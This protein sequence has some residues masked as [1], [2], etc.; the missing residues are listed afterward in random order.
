MKVNTNRW[1]RI[2]YTIWAPIYDAVGVLLD[3]MRRRSLAL[4]DI[5][6]D[7]KVL[8]VGCGTGLDLRYIS[9]PCSITATDITPAMV[10]RTLKRGKK[11]RL[12]V[13]ALVMD[14]QHLSFRDNT[15]D[16]IILHLIVAVVPVPTDALREAERVLKPGGTIVVLDK[17]VRKGKKPSMLRKVANTATSVLFSDI[18]RNAGSII[19]RTNLE[20]LQDIKAEPTGNFR[21]LLLHKREAPLAL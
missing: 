20:I 9:T 10:E 3:A 1:N 14:A 19:S 18:T 8:I 16:K 12:N 21:I 7:D 15:F 17:F 5:Q 13:G 11:L 2:R 6:K 4:L